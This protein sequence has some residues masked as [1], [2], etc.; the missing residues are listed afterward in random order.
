[1]N[2]KEVDNQNAAKVNAIRNHAQKLH[3]NKY[4]EHDPSIPITTNMREKVL[5]KYKN[6]HI[7]AFVIEPSRRREQEP[8]A[9]RMFVRLIVL[10]YKRVR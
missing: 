1:M 4:I 8:S 3:T 5:D 6:A 10:E 7:K 9:S 2:E